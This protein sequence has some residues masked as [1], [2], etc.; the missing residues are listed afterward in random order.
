ML[1]GHFGARGA[2][3]CLDHKLLVGDFYGDNAAESMKQVA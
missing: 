3:G 2:V 1:F